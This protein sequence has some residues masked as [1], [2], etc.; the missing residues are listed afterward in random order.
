LVDIHL[1]CVFCFVDGRCDPSTIVLPYGGNLGNCTGVVPNYGNCT[2]GCNN[3]YALTKPVAPHVCVDNVFI[4][5]QACDCNNK[6]QTNKYTKQQ[7]KIL[8]ARH[9]CI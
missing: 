9:F 7:R 3:H 8:N 1:L 2:I 6:Q 4:G 5:R